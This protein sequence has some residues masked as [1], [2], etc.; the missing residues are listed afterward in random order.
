MLALADD[1]QWAVMER[2]QG[3]VRAAEVATELRDRELQAAVA[4]RAVTGIES[5]L[6][7]GNERP[8]ISLRLMDSLVR[9]PTEQRPDRLMYLLDKASEVYRND[10]WQLD[11]ILELKS[12]LVP[13][14][15]RVELRR[16]QVASWRNQA[17]EAEGLLRVSHLERAFEIANTFGLVEEAGALRIALQENRDRDLGLT[18]IAGETAFSTEEVEGF[19]NQFLEPKTL[20]DALLAF[21]THGPPGGE[22]E[23]LTATVERQMREHPVQ[24]VFPK[25]VLDPDVGVPLF[26]ATDMAG[27]LRTEL[28]RSRLLAARVWSIFGV[29]IL[30]RMRERY[31]DPSHETITAAFVGQLVD[32]PIAERFA[33]ALELLWEHRADDSAH[34]S[35]PRLETV[36]RSLARTLR[37]PIMNEPQGD[38]VGSVRTLGGLLE[39]LDGAFPTPGW[40]AYLTSLLVDPLGLNLR[41][42]IAHG[43]RV[44]M[45][46]QDAALLL[47][48][49]AF[50]RALRVEP[51][52]DG[53]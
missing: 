36:I 15:E 10:P 41:N 47:H 20:A 3:L 40:H 11:T 1:D 52:Q 29:D 32:E 31:D 23:E 16:A 27:H 39:A 13:E 22:P 21:G 38:K 50:L 44:A 2:V 51:A 25:V 43:L 14:S 45:S 17:A 4:H 35:A 24:F 5:E 49:A 19:I 7:S 28:A 8:G 18:E 30:L 12:Q 37:V 48:G 46:D 6:A 53:S 42:V 26:R 33:R 34:L 9:L